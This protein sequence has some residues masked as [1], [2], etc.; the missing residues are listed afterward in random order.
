MPADASVLKPLLLRLL[1]FVEFESLGEI[2]KLL[3]RLCRS[4]R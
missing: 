3:G 2:G 4:G 1:F